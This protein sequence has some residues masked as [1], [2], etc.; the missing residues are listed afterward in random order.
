[1]RLKQFWVPVLATSILLGACSDDSTTGTGNGRL[2]VMLTDAPAADLAGAFVKI[3]KVVLIRSDADSTSTDSTRRVT[4]TSDVTSYINLLNLTGGQLLQLVNAETVPEGTYSQVRVYVDEAY[5][6]LKDG[7]YVATAGAALPAGVTSSGTLKCPSCS[8]SGYKVI[9]NTGGLTISGNSTVV[10]DFDA[11]QSFAHEAGKSGQ[12]IMRPVLHASATTVKLGAIVGNVALASGV[13]LPT[14]GG[15][16]TTVSQFVPLAIMN[17]DTAAGTTTSTGAYRI[18]AVFPGS[19]NLTYAKEL[20]FTNGDSLTVTATPSVS[21]VNV[22][23]GDS[24]SAN[25]SVTAATCH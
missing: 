15:A 2:T 23:Q 9:F 10:L 25:Y 17:G 7:R 8:Q 11:H 12:W 14:C 5:L 6:Q 24:A 4:I 1:M 22:A 3:S 16:A 18:S 21:S 19:Y 13:T 20:T